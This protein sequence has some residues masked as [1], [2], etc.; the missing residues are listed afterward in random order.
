MKCAKPLKTSPLR[1]AENSGELASVGAGAWPVPES[2]PSTHSWPSQLRDSTVHCPLLCFP[3]TLARYLGH[4]QILAKLSVSQVALGGSQRCSVG[5]GIP[6]PSPRSHS[7]Q[8]WHQPH[9]SSCGPT[10]GS[11]V[12]GVHSY[13]PKSTMDHHLPNLCGIFNV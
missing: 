13:P 4:R 10:M 9:H 5:S 1:S 8:E 2:H 6:T 7:K 3:H 12:T 11:R